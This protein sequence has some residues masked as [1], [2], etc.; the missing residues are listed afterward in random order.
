MLI[1]NLP[2]ASLVIC[3]LFG[4]VDMQALPMRHM[5]EENN[6]WRFRKRVENLGF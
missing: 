3:N 4:V 5:A 2:N 6:K 1:K